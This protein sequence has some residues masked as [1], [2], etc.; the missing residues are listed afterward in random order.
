MNE[1]TI[2]SISNELIS[3][4]T[5]NHRIIWETT[6]NSC[7][8]KNWT[9]HC[10]VTLDQHRK[11]VPCFSS[12]SFCHGWLFTTKSIHALKSSTPGGEVFLIKIDLATHF[13]KLPS[14]YINL[15]NTLFSIIFYF[16]EFIRYFYNYRMKEYRLQHGKLHWNVFENRSFIQECR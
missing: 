15:R 10:I 4:K 12:I 7:T 14:G 9:I 2:A 8:K 1:R 6:P 16:Y 5:S 3:L 11:R 13:A